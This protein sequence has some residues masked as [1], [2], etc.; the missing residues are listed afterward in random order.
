MVLAAT[1]SMVNSTAARMAIRML[2]MS[3]ICLANACTKAF[4]VDVLV[5]AEEL[6]NSASSRPATAS[7]CCG[8]LTRM[9]YQ[10]TSSFRMVRVSF[11]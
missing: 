5:S 6:A 9:T 7:D 4:S 2:P 11:R 1:S 3:P 8:S 10:P